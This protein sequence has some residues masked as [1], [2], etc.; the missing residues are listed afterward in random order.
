MGLC[1]MKRRGGPI[2]GRSDRRGARYDRFVPS[3]GAPSSNPQDHGWAALDR[4]VSRR[5]VLRFLGLSSVSG[6]VLVACQA[7]ATPTPAAIPSASPAAQTALAT[8]SPTA[9]ATSAPAAPTARPRGGTIRL[10]AWELDVGWLPW[11]AFGQE[12]AWN[13]CAQRLM[14]VAPDG[15][16]L[17]DLARKHSL[18]SDGREVTFEL[19][20]DARWHD[21]TPVTAADVAFTYNTCLKTKAGSN[22]GYLLAPISGSADVVADESRNASGIQ[23]VDDHT[24]TFAL[25]QANAEILSPAGPFAAI[26]IAPRHPFEGIALEEYPTQAIATNLFIGSGPMKM[27]EYKVDQFVNFEAWDG[28]AN[29]SGYRGLPG[30]DGVSIRIYADGDAQLTS[31]KVGEVD[32]Q[33]VR[34]PTGDQLKQLHAINGMSTQESRVGFNIFFSFNLK[35]P[36]VPL[37]KDKRVRQAFVWALDRHALVDDVL[38][39]AFR[40]PNVMNDW[41]APWASSDRLETYDPQDI[42]RARKLL[43]DA[44][45]DPTVVLD[46]R[47]Y[48]PKLDPD[49]PVIVEMWKAV[50][51]NSRLTPLSEAGFFHEFYE[52]KGEPGAPDE[53]PSYDVAIAFGFGTLDG[54][55]WGQANTLGSTRVYPNGYNSMRWVNEEWDREF[56]TALLQQDQET[57][58][59]HFKRCSELFNDEL[60]YAPLYQRVDYAIV[61][62]DLRG[63]EN[64][65][66]L[67]PAAGGVRY[68]EWYMASA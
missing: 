51:I 27:T 59:P 54:S 34:A 57:Q 32:F 10:G 65:T 1:P 45:W 42:E 56:A 35:Q 39:G 23:V 53:G 19:V 50:G 9:A 14:S 60:P 28:Y 7:A 4:R 44:G 24:I 52:S 66:I 64:A 17:Y 13:W 2:S 36:S 55:P 22:L 49:V 41:I 33:Y 3:P 8:A 43:A 30:A 67:H 58:A 31:T 40:V 6:V 11:A 12:F 20:E 46:V 5:E 38:G 29:G 61:S 25:D 68:W 63:P 26:F 16:I 21:G 18:S 15:T 47:H 48:P 62:D 37:L